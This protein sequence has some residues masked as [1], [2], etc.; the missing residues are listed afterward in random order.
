MP[1]DLQNPKPVKRRSLRWR[2]LV[3]LNVALAVIV[4]LFLYFDARSTW[5][6]LLAEKRASLDSDAETVL[7]SIFMH[8][9]DKPG[10]WQ[11]YLNEVAGRAQSTNP[12][13][14]IVLRAGDFVVQSTIIQANSDEQLAVMQKGA[15][16]ADR[17]TQTEAGPIIVGMAERGPFRV[18]VSD[19][20][21]DERNVFIQT[22]ERRIAGLWFLAVMLAMV[23][24]V[25][26]ERLVTRP[27]ARLIQSVRSVRAGELGSQAPVPKT[28]ELGYLVEEFNAMSEA[29]A[30]AERLRKLE[31]DRARRIQQGLMPACAVIPGLKAFCTYEPASDVGGDYYDVRR[32]DG[33]DLLCMAD[34]TGHGVPAAMGAAVVKT[35]LV[36]AVERTAKPAEVLAEINRGIAS[37]LID[38]EFASM[39]VA[40]FDR[41][42]SR[43]EFASAGHPPVYLIKTGGQI[44]QLEATGVLLGVPGA[45]SWDTLTVSVQPGDRFLAVTDGLAETVNAGGELFGEA[46]LLALVE[47]GRGQSLDEMCRSILHAAKDFRGQTPQ[48]DDVTMMAVEF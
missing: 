27:L 30:R 35:L 7:A 14:H 42:R 38:G 11:V 45:K 29:L 15:Q 5:H 28:E 17:T 43:I 48:R 31:M 22:V 10:S 2:L 26:V 24:N 37:I 41:A 46:R 21:V 40:A 34:M 9:Y 13:R 47:E 18:L 12:G 1:T 39:I 6:N 8:Q 44:Q 32:A 4:G 33:M 25:L 36:A 3:P 20:L 16:A 23:L 19:R